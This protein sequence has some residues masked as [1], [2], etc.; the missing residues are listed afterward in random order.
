MRVLT[1]LR[2]G[3]SIRY[4]DTK[5]SR[6]M[7]RAACMF[8]LAALGCI[9]C[10][11][12]DIIDNASL[13]KIEP[14]YEK[15][16]LAS[17]SKLEKLTPSK[18]VRSG[19]IHRRIG[20]TVYRIGGLDELAG[21]VDAAESLD[22]TTG[23]F[24]TL[25]AWPTPRFT[26]IVDV[27]GDRIC[28]GYGTLNLDVVNLIEVIDCYDTVADTWSTIPSFPVKLVAV[29]RPLATHGR[30]IYVF[31]AEDAMKNPKAAYVYE[32]AK[33]AWTELPS[34]P[35]QCWLN[36]PMIIGDKIY[37]FDCGSN[38]KQYLLLAYDIVGATWSTLTAPPPGDIKLPLRD[39]PHVHGNGFVFYNSFTNEVWHYDITMDQWS[40][41]PALSADVD[42]A[43]TAIVDNQL[44]VR[45]VH[46]RSGTTTGA[47][48][49]Y[50]IE[51][52]TW[53]LILDVPYQTGLTFDAEAVGSEIHYVGDHSALAP[54]IGN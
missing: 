46:V 7:C 3:Y 1:A 45:I 15:L 12:N 42:G 40:K 49:A 37:L 9:S 26:E 51:K 18:V 6:S 11:L 39:K 8:V 32:D 41:G 17:P 47:I 5:S 20:S 54:S 16:D 35:E 31:G 22:L 27:A 50:D 29:Q 44:Y 23:A 25:R 13:A 38:N 14:R 28:I 33:G 19:P 52:Q 2:I 10:N 21:V 24:K 34:M 48:H 30:D 4:M 36:H 53:S 43:A